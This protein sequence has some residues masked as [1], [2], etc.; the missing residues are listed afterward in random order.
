M[1][2]ASIKNTNIAILTF[3]L[4]GCAAIDHNDKQAATKQGAICGALMGMLILL[5]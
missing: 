4:A 5:C 3:T 2:I 1:K